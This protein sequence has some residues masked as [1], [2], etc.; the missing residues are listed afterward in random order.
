M[1]NTDAVNREWVN[2][3]A[4]KIESAY[5]TRS[6]EIAYAA[7]NAAIHYLSQNKDSLQEVPEEAIEAA[8]KAM[9]YLSGR[10]GWE[11]IG[12]HLRWVFRDD[13]RIMLEEI[14]NVEQFKEVQ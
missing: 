5:P 11:D 4:E 10:D 2:I 9:Y 6:H 12:Y 14:V 3:A 8:A 13:A 1:G 7:V